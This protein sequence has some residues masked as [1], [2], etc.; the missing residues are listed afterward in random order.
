MCPLNDPYTA[1]YYNPAGS[2][3]TTT[4]TTRVNIF[5]HLSLDLDLGNINIEGNFFNMSDCPISFFLSENGGGS[6][7][8]L[9]KLSLIKN[10]F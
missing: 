7:M 9:N 6:S 5:R 3:T 8:S 4:T 10:T 1:T 2:T